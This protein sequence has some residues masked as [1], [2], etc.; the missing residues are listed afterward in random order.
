MTGSHPGV[1]F[2]RR[3]RSIGMAILLFCLHRQNLNGGLLLNPE[4]NTRR[5]IP[6]DLRMRVLTGVPALVAVAAADGKPSA[7]KSRSKPK[8]K[9]NKRK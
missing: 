1:V 9:S 3:G 8:P 6:A 4:K 7:G 2:F 5:K